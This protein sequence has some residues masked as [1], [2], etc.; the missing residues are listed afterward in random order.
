MTIYVGAMCKKPLIAEG[1]L[2]TWQRLDQNQAMELRAA[3]LRW[4]KRWAPSIDLK[5]LVAHA[6]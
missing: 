6:L 2:A 1:A 5:N 4:A 3:V